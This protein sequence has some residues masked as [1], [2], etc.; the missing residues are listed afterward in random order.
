V[1]TITDDINSF[2]DLSNQSDL[3]RSDQRELVVRWSLDS[4]TGDQ[5]DIKD[6]HVY[7]SVGG[8]PYRYLGRPGNAS[9]QYFQWKAGNRFISSTFRD[10]PQ[11][12]SSYRFKVFIITKSGEPRFFGPYMNSG[13]IQFRTFN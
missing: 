13:S 6:Y 12:Q 10:G 9:A 4:S 8:D 2:T 1:I 5:N 3:D 7:V 11:N